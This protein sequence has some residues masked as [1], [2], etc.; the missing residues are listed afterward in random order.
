MPSQQLVEQDVEVS[1]ENIGGISEATV[2]LS[3]GVT[4]LPGRNATNR[5]SF[6]QSIMAG[7]GSEK[8]SLKA[9]ADEGHVELTIGEETYTRTLKRRGGT[10]VFDGNPY[11]DDPE[12]ADLFA[13]L[14]ENNEARLAVARSDDLRDIIMRPIDT[15]EIDAEIE[16]KKRERSA[17]DDEINRLE[18]L[19]SELPKLESK[20]AEIKNELGDAREERDELE[21][22]I[23]ALET[24]VNE[25]KDK[26][27]ELEEAFGKVRETRSTLDDLQFDLRTERTSLSELESEHDELEA[28][29]KEADDLGESPERLGGR[30]EELRNRKQSINERLNQ[31]GSIISFNEEMLDGE[32]IAL[33]TDSQADD[34]T[35]ELMA[36]DRTTCW[37]CGSTVE[38]DSIEDTLAQLRDLRRETLTERNEVDSEISELVDRRSTLRNRRNEIDRAQR[39]LET[40]AS[41]IEQGKAR[42]EDLET[43]IEET[44]AELEELEAAAEAVETDD[45]DKALSLHKERNRVD[46]RIDRLESDLTAVESDIDDHEDRISQKETLVE[47]RDTL[48]DRIA[49]LRTRVDRIEEN[50]VEAFNDHM[51]TMLDILDYENLD[52]I[53]IER[54]ETTVREGRKN[55]IQTRFDLHIVRSTPEGRAYED[56]IDH[57]SESERE[58]TGLVFALAGYLVHEVHETVPFM[59][60]DSLEAIDAE[61]I[62]RIVGY[63]GEYADYLVVALLPEDA[64]PLAGEHPRVEAIE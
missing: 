57:L 48:A 46:V 24:G 23:E 52:R 9:D 19:E 17:V 54:R 11:L 50:A 31:L 32:G 20:R 62:A 5:T 56:T 22:E 34:P 45:H 51:E 26:K 64:E 47:K 40:V 4:V 59:I 1:V 14:L 29:L 49:E 38:T 39:R 43:Q 36:G 63:F 37:T 21:A 13:F 44:E 60:L 3:P 16:A 7:L 30:I 18:R 33:E 6:L 55:V 42:I 8:P 28:T 15:D 27:A 12:L 10:V 2:S 58:V 35:A 53:W 25:S 61:R 41:K